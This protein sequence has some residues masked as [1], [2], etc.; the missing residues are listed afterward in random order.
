MKF[1]SLDLQADILKGVADAGFEKCTPIQEQSLPECL[2]GKDIIAQSQTGTGKTAVFVLT[3][4]NRLMASGPSQKPRA[5]VMVPTRE[6]AVQVEQDARKLGAHLPLKTLTVYGGVDYDKQTSV[7]KTGVDLV[8]ATPGRMIDLYKSKYLSLDDIEMFVIDEADRMFDMGFA[9][10]ITYIASRLLKD[11]PRQTMLFS[12]TIDSNVERLA[13]RYMKPDIMRVEIEPEQVTVDTIDQKVIYVS[14]EEKLPM[15][16]SLLKRPDAST[17]IIFTNMKRTAEMLEWKLQGNGFQ[18]KALTGDMTQAK[19]QK[20]IEGMKAGK[21]HILVATDVAAR[22]L[23]IEG[24]THVINYDLPEEAANYVHRVGRTARAG[25]TGKAY[26]LVCESYA[27][28]LP[29]IE[30]YI[31]RKIESEW[32]EDAEMVKDVAGRYYGKPR[33]GARGVRSGKPEGRSGGRPGGRSASRPASRSTGKPAAR[34]AAKSGGRPGGGRGAKPAATPPGKSDEEPVT[35]LSLGPEARKGRPRSVE[36]D[37]EGKPERPGRIVRPERVRKPRPAPAIISEDV[38]ASAPS[39]APAGEAGEG[40]PRRRRRR[41]R[42]PSSA[43]GAAGKEAG[44]QEARPEQPQ[45]AQRKA[46][47]LESPERRGPRRRRRPPRGRGAQTGATQGRPEQQG[48]KAGED[49]RGGAGRGRAPQRATEKTREK[50]DSHQAP[51]ERKASNPQPAAAPRTQ[52]RG[53]FLKKFFGVF[54]KKA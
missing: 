18:A 13:S 9:P 19:R 42:R 3:I 46:E 39:F 53:G 34:S 36:K 47:G 37:R 54:K 38:S 52:G 15:L 8:V 25:K 27:F 40:A 28:N 43:R 11:K 6:L 32:I 26:S 33:G 44:T 1:D 45:G 49:L 31:E 50:I 16:L 29:E 5:L 17:V 22:G 30:K 10:D 51:A 24:V 48:K 2:A 20:V 35:M 41:R 14:N 12:A 7:L 21:V 23:H 4:F